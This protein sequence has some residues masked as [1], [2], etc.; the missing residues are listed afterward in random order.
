MVGAAACL[1]AREQSKEVPAAAGALRSIAH[2]PFHRRI[3]SITLSSTR[4][5]RHQTE[6]SVLEQFLRRGSRVD[7]GR[8][9]QSAPYRRDLHD[10]GSDRGPSR[11]G[12]RREPLRTVRH[13]AGL[14]LDQRHL[15]VRRPAAAGGETRG[16][17]TCRRAGAGR[18]SSTCATPR[19]QRRCTLKRSRSLRPRGDYHRG[20]WRS[21]PS[22]R[23][24]R[25]PRCSMPSGAGGQQPWLVRREAT[26]SSASAHR[27]MRVVSSSTRVVVV[28]PTA[29]PGNLGRAGQVLHKPHQGES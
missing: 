26:G 9:H 6:W 25:T 19:V 13:H 16:A 12:H 24:R 5:G 29:F 1:R 18:W 17:P 21:S 14:P 3:G 7:L 2:S 27:S 10:L 4:P 22:T 28:E 20:T 15:E 8:R 11:I 23:T